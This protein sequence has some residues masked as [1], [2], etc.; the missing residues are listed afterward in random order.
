[1]VGNGQLGILLREFEKRGHLPIRK[2]I[3][4]TG[5]DTGDQ[6]GVH[7]EPDVDRQFFAAKFGAF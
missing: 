3:T 2:L 7:D 1:M 4:R 6:A 5:R